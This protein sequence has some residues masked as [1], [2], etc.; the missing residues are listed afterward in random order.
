MNLH[1]D[2]NIRCRFLNSYFGGMFLWLENWTFNATHHGA[3]DPQ[4]AG[5]A[6]PSGSTVCFLKKR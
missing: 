5:S 2:E 3:P 4:A 6:S 1:S